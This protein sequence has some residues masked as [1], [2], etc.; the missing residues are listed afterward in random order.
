ME[1]EDKARLA[2]FSIR[3]FA[4]GK[5]LPLRSRV[6]LF[7][8]VELYG[9]EIIDKPGV[10]G[11]R[12]LAKDVGFS[13]EALSRNLK[14]LVDKGALIGAR[15]LT[16][17]RPKVIYRLSHDLKE[18][19]LSPSRK[20][21]HA[22]W[23]VRL[24]GSDD[25][26]FSGLS[27]PE[28]ALLAILWGLLP[29]RGLCVLD[30]RSVS[31]LSRLA[32]VD[33]ST[34]YEIIQRLEQKKM[35]V[36]SGAA[37]ASRGAKDKTKTYFLLGPAVL[38]CWPRS[39]TWQVELKGVLGWFAGR[40]EQFSARELMRIVDSRALKLNGIDPGLKSQ[41]LELLNDTAGREYVF[42][43]CCAAISHAFSSGGSEYFGSNVLYPRVQSALLRLLRMPVLGNGSYHRAIEDLNLHE[44]DFRAR[45]FSDFSEQVSFLLAQKLK[46]LFCFAP[47]YQDLGRGSRL[48]VC[49]PVRMGEVCK[50]RI[51]FVTDD[52]D[53]GDKFGAALLVRHR[54]NT[55]ELPDQ[56]LEKADG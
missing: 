40:E 25:P 20:D 13:K 49:Y 10:G 7:R 3:A 32:D 48:M 16:S 56:L 31:L 8:L 33:S 23:L 54:R 5:Q 1:N 53:A 14:I 2:R 26:A 52:G 21:F 36:A 51:D 27:I 41:L 6:L 9:L 28:K 42:D 12:R 29:R 46:Q 24:L 30:G 55:L 4:Y 11:I 38:S 45:F 35:L 17:G 19:V 43:Q 34:F 39:Y 47:S 18:T 50:M 44:L 22:P 15:E 37:F